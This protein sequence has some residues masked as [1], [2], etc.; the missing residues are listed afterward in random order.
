MSSY[1]HGTCLGRRVQGT[2]KAS[3]LGKTWPSSAGGLGGGQKRSEGLLPYG[4]GG[5]RGF[6]SLKKITFCNFVGINPG[7]TH[8]NTVIIIVT[9]SFFWFKKKLSLFWGPPKCIIDPRH[10]AAVPLGKVAP[11]KRQWNWYLKN[12]QELLQWTG[13]GVVGVWAPET[14]Y[15]KALWW[16]KRTTG[17]LQMQLREH[18]WVRWGHRESQAIC[19]LSPEQWEVTDTF[20][21]RRL[22]DF[23][24]HQ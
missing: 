16:R 11:R 18:A 1:N 3:Y 8:H 14:A 13:G 19:S 15:T 4:G 5:D 7:W 9:V 10:Y 23:G 20:Q 24:R 22:N 2:M 6:F 17:E 21:G 12:K